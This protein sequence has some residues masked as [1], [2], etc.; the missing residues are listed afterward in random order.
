MFLP[1]I[2]W[3]SVSIVSCPYDA[4]SSLIWSA[5]ILIVSVVVVSSI[6]LYDLTSLP[7]VFFKSFSVLWL[8]DVPAVKNTDFSSSGVP[9]IVNVLSCVSM[10]VNSSVF[11]V[12]V[13]VYVVSDVV[14]G[15]VYVML[16]LNSEPV[17]ELCV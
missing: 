11:T 4:N 3:L 14:V 17:D 8:T 1:L 9:F 7:N 12:I 5:V 16:Y 13:I 10:Y 6:I 2:S 15:A